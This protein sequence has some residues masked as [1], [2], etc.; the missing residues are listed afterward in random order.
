[1]KVVM[2]E[3]EDALQML[4][5]GGVRLNPDRSLSHVSDP[6]LPSVPSSPPWIL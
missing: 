2:G 3:C 1:M 6:A 4:R 5:D